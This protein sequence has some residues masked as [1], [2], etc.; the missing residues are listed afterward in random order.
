M[1]ATDQLIYQA[2]GAGHVAALTFDDGPNPGETD[3]LLDFLAANHL[4]AVFCVIGQNIEAPGGAE[5]LSRIVDEGHVLCNHTTGYADMGDWTDEQI[6]ADLTEN[7]RI[8]RET[9]GDPDAVVPYFRAPNGSWG[10]TPQVAAD[11]GMQPLDVRNV[12]FDWET[13]DQAELEAALRAA[14]VPGELVLAHDGGG[15]RSGTVAAVKN[16]VTEYL[17]AGWS[18]TLPV[19]AHAGEAVEVELAGL[20]PG[21]HVELALTRGSAA[22]AAARADHRSDDDDARQDSA[23]RD[24]ARADSPGHDVVGQDGAGG[25]DVVARTVADSAGKLSATIMTPAEA[26]P[27]RYTVLALDGGD[28]IG[29]AD[30][31]VGN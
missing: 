3:E 30:V 5:L 10:G 15:D 9:L 28:V 13:Q 2:Q 17:D 11:M 7:L 23:G 18:F 25:A 20:E 6:R 24:G 1:N 14:L 22:A 12:I 8:I 27:G 29:A 19:G 16:V 31:H 21:Q 26:R 4:R